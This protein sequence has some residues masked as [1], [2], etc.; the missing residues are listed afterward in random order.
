[1]MGMAAYSAYDSY[2]DSGEGWI[3]DVPAH[4][5]TRKLKQLFQEKK[6]RPNLALNC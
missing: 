5:E 1:M 6:H 3:E 4:W 2:K